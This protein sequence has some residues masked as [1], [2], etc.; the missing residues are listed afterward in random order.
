M[1]YSLAPKRFIYFYLLKSR[2]SWNAL[3]PQ[4]TVIQKLVF[5]LLALENNVTDHPEFNFFII[6]YSLT[7]AYK[8]SYGLE[9]NRL[10]IH[11]LFS[12]F[13]IFWFIGHGE[14]Y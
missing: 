4:T 8:K 2:R 12:E 11:D 7:S 3:K 13:C 1:S 10:F 5:E 9:I 14:L 6:E